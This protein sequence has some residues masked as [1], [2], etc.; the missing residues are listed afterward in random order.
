MGGAIGGEMA[1]MGLQG[2]FGGS[3]LPAAPDN[4][5]VTG[6][7]QAAANPPMIAPSYFPS[8]LGFGYQPGYGIG[9]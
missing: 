9:G 2:M 1:G 4:S 6:A 5:W 3:G 8:N 7:Q